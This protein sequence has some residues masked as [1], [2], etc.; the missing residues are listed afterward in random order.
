MYSKDEDR[1]KKYIYIH[2]N[3]LVEMIEAFY[4]RM[5]TILQSESGTTEFIQN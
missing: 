4:N 2:T 3:K 5:Y 1:K